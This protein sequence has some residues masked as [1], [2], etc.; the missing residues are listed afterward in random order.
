VYAFIVRRLLLGLLV[1]AGVYTLT[2]FAV[3][4]APGDPF[5]ALENP[6][7]QKEDIE[8]LRRAWGYDQPIGTRFFVQIR[9]MF[10]ADAEVLV[11]DLGGFEI[12]V[13][14]G[15]DGGNAVEARQLAPPDVVHL[16]PTTRSR[17]EENSLPV[18]LHRRADGTWGAEPIRP[19]AYAFA[20]EV[21]LVSP[22]P[23]VVTELRRCGLRLLARDGTV[24]AE[25]LVASPPDEL[26]LAS[27]VDTGVTIRLARADADEGAA[28]PARYGPQ[29]I[30]SGR[31]R[32]AVQEG[33]STGE[34]VVPE[35][36]LASA[37]LT[38][39]L[40]TSVLQKEP[41]VSYLAR[42]LLHTLILAT[43]ALFFNFLIGIAIGVISAVRRGKLLD[44]GLTLGALFV[45]SMPSFWLGLMLM[46]LLAVRLQWLP[47]EGMNSVGENW[48]ES[49]SGLLDMLWHLVLPAI[50]LGI[51]GAAAT[52]RYQRASLIE[53]LGQD[54]IRTARAKGLDER[55]VIWKHAMRNSLLP[56]ITLIGLYLP[57][58]VSGS[59]ITETIF[60][61]PG[62]G[63]EAIHAIRGRDVFVVT[64]I[65][66]IATTMVVCGNLL[67][68]TLYAA[69]D[70]RVRLR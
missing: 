60:S 40:G 69:A 38:F 22:Q 46:M 25:R 44:H 61:W 45:Y 67:A 51:G 64:G 17:E 66:M 21:L 52:A 47:A 50:V 37:G 15:A 23:G 20:D 49:F 27:V 2:F 6:K 14:G 58:L 10:W 28:T 39:D 18:A 62:M 70:P 41:V 1:I 5:S 56:V 9:K 32:L 35:K 30:A 63:R 3:N 24:S 4:L 33:S 42:P 36:L 43:A 19:G 11:W 16:E 31:Y 65:T 8:R 48:R 34:V 26:V 12:T 7:M 54:F 53:V 68:D 13:R 29:S 59:V 55:R 57:F